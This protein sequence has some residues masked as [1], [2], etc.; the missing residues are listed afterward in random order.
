MM[1]YMQAIRF[2]T[3]FINDDKYYKINYPEHNLVRAQNQMYLLKAL[4]AFPD[5]A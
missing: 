3:D 2:F 4:K 1:I 5:F